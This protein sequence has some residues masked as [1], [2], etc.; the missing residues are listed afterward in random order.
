[1]TSIIYSKK[2]IVCI[3]E[4]EQNLSAPNQRIT[5]SKLGSISDSAPDCQFIISSHSPFL[6]KEA[7]KLSTY[8]LVN[9]DGVTTIKD[10][11]TPLFGG[12]AAAD[13]TLGMTYIKANYG[14]KLEDY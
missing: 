13:N 5:L 14:D 6:L 9:N 1:M 11:K 2:S 3:E 12:S 7:E 4:L 8:F 10:K